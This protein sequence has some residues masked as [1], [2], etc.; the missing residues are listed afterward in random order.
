MNLVEL[1]NPMI[2]PPE[3]VVLVP[4]SNRIEVECENGLRELESL[5]Y[6]VR[7][8][9]GFSAIDQARNQLATTAMMDGFQATLWIDSDIGFSGSDVQKLAAHNLPVVC[10]I[11]PKKGKRSLAMNRLPHDKS[12]QFGTNGGLIEI[13]Y[14]GAGFLWVTR[15]VYIDVQ[16]KFNLPVCNSAFDPGMIP[17]FLP[18]IKREYHLGQRPPTA[19]YFAED[20]AFLNRVKA[21][22][23]KLMAD[24]S[25][26]LSH[27]GNYPYQWE[28]A[29]SEKKR[30]PGYKFHFKSTQSEEK[31]N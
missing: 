23:Y 14:V 21:C 17:F 30:Y 31:N 27:I 12:L 7:R 9:P 1:L 19:R 13:D 28:D 5:G 2:Q 18:E 3:C 26:R 10:G 11:Y 22:G 8:V 4:F 15:Q 20:Y 29:G 24:T 6:V 16:L 25:I